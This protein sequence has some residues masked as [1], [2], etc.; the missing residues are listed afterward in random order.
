MSDK[1]KGIADAYLAKFGDIPWLWVQGD[2]DAFEAMM[3]D[4][5]KSGKPIKDFSEA[6]GIPPD[7]VI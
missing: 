1:F 6:H 4:A 2:Y 3:A 5:L 7:A